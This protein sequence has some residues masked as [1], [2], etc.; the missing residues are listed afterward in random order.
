MKTVIYLHGF[1]S[2]PASEKAA[3]TQA[4]FNS[5]VKDFNLIVPALEAAPLAAM[6]GV[7]VMI[8]EMGADNVAG[9]IG[10]SLGGY[11]SLYLQDRVRHI[12]GFTPPAALINPAMR[13]YELLN[14]YLGENTN[15]YTGK[16]YQVLPEH[17][18][19]LRQ[20]D[21][22][23]KLDKKRIYLLTQTGDETLDYRQAL[24]DLKGARMW[25]AHGGD[26]A[27]QEYQRTLPSIMEF[28][29]SHN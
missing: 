11:Y 28:I 7:E 27:F 14:D 25:V 24:S 10:S 12:S 18:E 4:Y 8:D 2:S 20:L 9:L 23:N 5:S 1:N 6:A 26:H 21:V 29:R 13:P 3:M 17:M 22:L 15:L 16:R 19:E